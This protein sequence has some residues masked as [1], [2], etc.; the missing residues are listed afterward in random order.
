MARKKTPEVPAVLQQLSEKCSKKDYYSFLKSVCDMQNVVCDSDDIV[1]LQPHRWG[2]CYYARKGETVAMKQKPSRFFSCGGVDYG[3]YDISL[4]GAKN[5]VWFE[6]N[7]DMWHTSFLITT[8]YDGSETTATISIG[9]IW[10]YGNKLLREAFFLQSIEE[11]KEILTRKNPYAMQCSID[12]RIYPTEFLMA[13]EIEQLAKAG[14]QFIRYIGKSDLNRYYRLVK[15][16]T[17]LKSIFKTSKAVY[18]ALKNEK[19]LAVWDAFRKMAKTGKITKEEVVRA[20]EAGY[21]SRRLTLINDILNK[22]YNDKQIFTFAS[23]QRY[24]ERVDMYEAIPDL[25]ALQLLKDYLQSCK[26][27]EIEP[28]IDSDSLKREHDVAARLCTQRR[29]EILSRKMEGSCDYLKKYDYDEDIFFVRGIR[30]YD[31][32]IDE[33]RQQRNCVASYAESIVNKRSL[34]YVMRE[35]AH[36]EK[37]L[38]TIELTPKGEVRQALLACN[39]GIRNAS[40]SAFIQR[41]KKVVKTRMKKAA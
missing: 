23:L 5:L 10:D 9:T 40:Q 14:Y 34:I 17:D 1:V 41:W 16:G 39:R 25:D 7:G 36:P 20:Y 28:K 22:K 31:D 2:G 3:R 26:F 29:N 38:I 30:N 6:E 21:D 8:R 33:A 19:N 32:L 35:K 15:S 11:I 12:E 37:S 27:L 24:L 4:D 13:P 18:T